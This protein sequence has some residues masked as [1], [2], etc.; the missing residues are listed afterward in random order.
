MLLVGAGI[1]AGVVALWAAPAAAS[2]IHVSNG[3]DFI[4]AFNSNTNDTIVLDADIHLTNV[5]C[6]RGV[7]SVNGPITVDGQNQFKI[8]QECTGFGVLRVNDTDSSSVTLRGVTITGGN[9]AG[10]GAGLE[11]EGTGALTI[12]H[13]TFVSNA[14]DSGSDGGGI[15][16]EGGP[17]TITAS[18]FLNNQAGDD[19]GAINCDPSTNQ[20]QTITVTGSTFAG[21]STVTGNSSQ[22]GAV[23]MEAPNCSLTMVNST[24]TGN[25]S[26]D[27]AAIS[28]EKSS[29]HITLVYTD[30]VNNTFSPLALQAASTKNKETAG[31]D[32]AETPEPSS[33][34]GAAALAN[35][36]ANVFLEN[37]A[38]LTIFGTVVTGP[39]GGPD[40]AGSGGAPMAGVNSLGYNFADDTSC[41]LTASTDKQA[42]GNNPQLG[43]LA[44]NGGPTRTLLPQTGSP[45]ID[46][47]VNGACQTASGVVG[48]ITT[49]QRG[50]VRPQVPGGLCDIGAV[51]IQAPAPVVIT[52]T[53]TG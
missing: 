27:L 50:L 40:C 19:G 39:T 46:A 18:T 14:T 10:D 43:A 9:Q 32:G 7:R 3:A 21:N 17:V 38:N 33:R 23:D 31:K 30:V 5:L 26:K 48:S 52:P 34:V 45:L 25:T 37:P 20:S 6:S 51:E 4:A 29:D 11:W 16:A 44:D 13:S 15:D 12:D 49:D 28:G 8:I 1:S 22:G 35:S 2:T 53:F 24:V 47:I 36:P 41:G 42:S